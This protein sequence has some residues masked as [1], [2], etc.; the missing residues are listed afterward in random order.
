MTLLLAPPNSDPSAKSR[1]AD[2]VAALGHETVADAT[3]TVQ[4]ILA[5]AAGDGVKGSAGWTGVG[6]VLDD[7]SRHASRSANANA[8]RRRRHGAAVNEF[9]SRC[10]VRRNN[11]E[12][13]STERAGR[14]RVASAQPE[15][16]KVAFGH[17]ERNYDLRNIFTVV[18]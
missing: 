8:R 18:Y 16:V 2:D 12:F 6:V 4:S 13:C 10:R 5:T 3:L 1:D 17:R 14:A 15:I 9:G 11:V 7:E